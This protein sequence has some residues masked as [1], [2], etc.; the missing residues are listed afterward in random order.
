MGG[1]RTTLLAADRLQSACLSTLRALGP[2]VTA[3]LIAKGRV[4]TL[5]L[6]LGANTARLEFELR[7][8]RTHLSYSLAAG[9]IEEAKHA[10]GPWLLLAPYVP[11]PIGQHLAS[12]RVSYVDAV[13]NCHIE[14]SDRLVAHVEGRKLARDLG[15]RIP[16]IASH[17]LLFAIL[18]QPDL[19]LAP[20]RRVAVAAGIGRSTALELRGRLNREGLLDY[21]PARGLIRY[22]QLLDRWLTAYAEVLR[23]SWLVTRCRPRVDGT[24]ALEA[25]IERVF[26]NRTWAWG[27]AAA[28]CRMLPLERGTETVLHVADV[29]VDVLAQ[30]QAVPA[31]DGPLIILQTPGALAYRG[32]KPHLAHP[33][34]VY[35]EL[36]STD[37]P[38]ASAAASAIAQSFLARA[39]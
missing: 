26:A 35:S 34:L 4:P 14:T 8:T 39:A 18:A 15:A 13:G 36:L 3:E 20:V 1:R 31:S 16:G 25:L 21:Y 33:L 28:A 7:T 37:D 5:Q 29:P 10:Q 30:L 12:K 2:M 6:R 17:Q 11:G 38:R 24:E 23:K 32:A 19:V 22:R 9:L 27:G